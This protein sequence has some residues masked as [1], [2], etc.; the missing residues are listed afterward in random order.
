MDRPTDRPSFDA[1]V[2]LPSESEIYTKALM[3][4]LH[5]YIDWSQYR[6][7]FESLPLR[8][9]S[10]ESPGGLILR[11][12]LQDVRIVDVVDVCIVSLP[13]E[14]QFVAL[15]YVWGPDSAKDFR[16]LR[17]NVRDLEIPGSLNRIELPSTIVDA[18]TV[19]RQLEHRFLW[20]DRLCIIQDEL[21]AQAIQLEQMASLYHQAAFTIV[22]A[23][24]SSA[25]HGLLGV[26][27]AREEQEQLK[28][29]SGLQLVETAPILKQ[30]LHKTTWSSRAWTFQEYLS[31]TTMMFFTEHGIYVGHRSEPGSLDVYT[32]APGVHQPTYDRLHNSFDALETY[33]AKSLTHSSDRLRGFSGILY[34]TH[35]NRTTHGQPIDDFDRSILWRR[36]GSRIEPRTQEQTDLIPTWSWT[37]VGG[38]IEFYQKYYYSYSLAYWGKFVY[39]D[40]KVVKVVIGPPNRICQGEREGSDH[41]V[42]AL[43]WL[44]GCVRSKPPAYLKIDCS[45]AEYEKRLEERWSDDNLPGYWEDAFR[46]YKTV[47]LF[48][49][50]PGNLLDVT[51]RVIAHTQKASFTLDRSSRTGRNTQR[52]WE[53]PENA[54]ILIRSKGLVAGAIALDED[55]IDS[56]ASRNMDHCDVDLI[57]L[58]VDPEGHRFPPVMPCFDSPSDSLSISEFFGCMCSSNG[59]IDLEPEAHLVECPRH[60]DFDTPSPYWELLSPDDR[61]APGQRQSE[62]ARAFAKHWKGLSYFGIDGEPLHSWRHVP[63]LYVMVVARSSVQEGSVVYRRLGIGR[64]YL[65]RWVE[66][67]PEF[68]TIVLE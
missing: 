25:A 27:R 4:R 58:S 66:A 12:P 3:A 46:E 11:Q 62:K 33:T 52:P 35:G 38:S 67:S 1:G 24:G 17:T 16:T 49:S 14:A 45:S 54:T 23:A 36:R 61:F 18:I 39:E 59:T 30:V 10:E 53:F 37:S 47:E 64:V 63:E 7:W 56:T 57:A 55:L 65:K 44:A 5:P 13:R 19:C 28:L 21:H 22:A 8:R 48:E 26:S 34:A 31:S 40:D 43:A 15:S 42:A 2:S 68:E 20:V 51:R 50:V 41:A 6:T 9:P 29:N 60:A 32:E